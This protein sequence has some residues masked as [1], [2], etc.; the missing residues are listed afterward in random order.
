MGN[1]MRII[2]A[3]AAG[4]ALLLGACAQ[5]AKPPEVAVSVAQENWV[6]IAPPDNVTTVAFIDTFEFLPE[7]KARFPSSTINGHDRASLERLFEQVAAEPVAEDRLEVLTEVS[8]LTE[9]PVKEWR[10]VRVFKSAVACNATRGELIKV[11]GEQTK[12]VGAYAR[13]PRE[14]FQWPLLAKSFQ[15]SRCVPAEMAP[16]VL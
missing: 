2:V 11:T 6:L 12:K 1:A 4:A 16:S 3:F 10:E 5:T 13:M 14:E 8:V 9:A 7:H 15:L